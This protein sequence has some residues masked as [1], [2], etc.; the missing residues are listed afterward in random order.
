[1]SQPLS[2]EAK[3]DSLYEEIKSFVQDYQKKWQ[4]H[5]THGNMLTIISIFISLAVTIAGFFNYSIVAA[6]FGALSVAVL[7]LQNQFAETE[8]AGFYRE[9]V[10]EG[11]NLMTNLKFTV[12]TEED[13][14]NTVQTFDKLRMHGATE[15]PKGQAMTLVNNMSKDLA[16]RN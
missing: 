5:N 16:N 9:V 12:K 7:T 10:A 1:M 8:K 14:V 2:F 15:V 13:F 4:D 6:L 3:K 11:Q